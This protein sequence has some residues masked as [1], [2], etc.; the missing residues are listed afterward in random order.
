MLYCAL[1]KSCLINREHLEAAI[2]FW[3]YCEATVRWLFTEKTG[4]HHA[5]KIL[6]ELRH[7]SPEGPG[8]KSEKTF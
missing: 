8:I 2:A 4:N 5:D 6:W 1:D 7:L 3:S